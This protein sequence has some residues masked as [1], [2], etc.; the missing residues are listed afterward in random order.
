VNKARLL[1][2]IAEL[3]RGKLIE[4]ISELR[5]ESDKD[6]MR[7]VIE[8][9]RNENAEIV[10]NNLYK[11]TPMESVFGVNMVALLDG[12]PRL[13]NLKDMIEAFVRH[14][15]EIVTRRTVYDL[16]KA[17]ERGHILEGLAVALANIDEVIAL[18]KASPTPPEAKA[19]L[20]AR[21]W[22]GGAVPE[23]LARAG[24]V[25]ARPEGLD[26]AL[27]LH[28]TI[29]R[30]S[31]VQAQAILDLRLHRLTGLE[32]DKIL[33]EYAELLDVI[34][35]LS[36]ILA[37]PE[38]LLGVIRDELLAIRDQYGDARRT[39]IE[40]D[41]SDLTIEDLITPQDVVVTL[42]HGGYAKSQP[43]SEYRAQGRGGRGR[44][45]T[46]MKDE[47]FVEK[48][49]VANTHDTL[50]CFSS[51]GQLY[52][53]KVYQL[54]MAGRASRG[55]PIVNL[56]PLEEGER[57][58][59]VLPIR[60]Y[61]EDKYIFMATAF[62][63]VKKTSLVAF[64][65]PRTAGIIAVGLEDGDQ[66]VGVDITD[67]K[68]DVM[69]FTTE[70]KAIRFAE[71]DV[72]PMGRNA[73]GVRGIRLPDGERVISLIIPDPQGLILIASE[74]G[75]G[76]LTSVEEFPVH[77]R[78]GQ[79]VIAIQTTERNGQLVAAT[80]VA[81]TNELMLMSSGGTL[82]RTR[83][84]EVSVLGRNT[85]GVRLIRLDEGERLI[86]VESVEPEPESEQD[87][88]EGEGASDAPDAPAA[89]GDSTAPT[90]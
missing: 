62:G 22:R 32:Q 63:T 83:A 88:E 16:R 77:G 64:S 54:P 12:Q 46:Q 85:Q 41:E 9:K 48:L 5:D 87:A 10:L 56:L 78:G 44:S 36:D 51:R 80:Q 35:D 13:L 4:G 60:E 65:R 24:D 59:A 29:Y 57:I 82:V 20:V 2:R 30:L 72:R 90:H 3:V 71:D 69:M 17:R 79:G 37:R 15:R 47:D 75:Y 27:G 8:L 19:A 74:N 61:E 58:T 33:A 70:G 45:A 66:L 39:R 84:A 49:F 40:R 7:V 38:R 67:G 52:W 31:E 21:E 53:L 86:G 89:D 18:I 73:A 26:A 1:E 25:S 6:G 11:Q 23:M 34:R 43:V 55:K 76:K 42:S 81:T 28:G 68:R 50:L 14:R